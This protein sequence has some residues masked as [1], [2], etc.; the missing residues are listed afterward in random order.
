M[1]S[2]FFRMKVKIAP[3][4]QASLP[5]TRSLRISNQC[6]HP[7]FNPSIFSN[8]TDHYDQATKRGSWQEAAIE[9]YKNPTS[10]ISKAS[11]EQLKKFGFLKDGQLTAEANRVIQS[12]LANN[13]Q[14][15]PCF[16]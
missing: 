11:E 6:F 7:R 10:T 14:N 2:L 16:K 9:L 8:D 5:L 1:K 3:S 15:S 13:N 4:P 12:H